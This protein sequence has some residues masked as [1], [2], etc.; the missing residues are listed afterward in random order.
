MPVRNDLCILNM[1]YYFPLKIFEDYE[2]SA[3][4]ALDSEEIEGGIS[5]GDE[6]LQRLA[7]I[8]FGTKEEELDI[9][10][11]T[12]QAAARCCSSDEEVEEIVVDQSEKW[13]CETILSTYS[14]LYNHPAKIAMPKV[15]IS[16][17]ILRIIFITYVAYL[18]FRD[19]Q[20][21]K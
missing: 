11:K 8:S 6:I 9:K 7:D 16:K 17:Y 3:I 19:Q 13:D 14:N 12:L 4:G 15:Y 10:D 18:S 21:L 5:A 2:E 20:K 1:R